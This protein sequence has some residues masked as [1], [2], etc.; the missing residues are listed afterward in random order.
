MRKAS[1]PTVLILLGMLGCAVPEGGPALHRPDLR[2]DDLARNEA[3]SNGLFSSYLATGPVRWNQGWPWQLD[4]SGVAWDN[5]VTATAI[6]PRIVVMA[7][8]YLRPAGTPVVFHDRNGRAHPRRIQQVALLKDHGLPCDV[9]VGLLDQALPRQIRIYPLPHPGKDPAGRLALVTDQSRSL[10]FHRVARAEQNGLVLAH[11]PTLPASSRKSLV[12]G[13]SGNPS[14][15]LSR[16]E[17]VLIETHTFG[18][19]GMGP[20]Y[21]SAEVQAA[22]RKAIAA[23]DPSAGFRLT[24]I[25][26]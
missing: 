14:F 25:S 20:W 26:P 1:L 5:S 10:W 12:A 2:L 16:G 11:D 3:G 18:G 13:D 8:H 19:P 17:L 4:L 24:P 9:A 23:L 7:A 22:L 15:L 6:H 21:G